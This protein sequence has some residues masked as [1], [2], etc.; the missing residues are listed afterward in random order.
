MEYIL[1]Q[2]INGVCQGAIYALMA[3]GYSVVVGVT[4]MVT[5]THGEVM[6]IGA[7]ASFYIFQY[8]GSHIVLGLLGAFAASWIL[9][10]LVY[11]ICYEHFFN[12]PRHISLICTVGFSMLVQNLAQICFGANKKP[13]LNIIENRVF[14][15]GP[16]RISMIQVAIV[17]I[18]LAL[19]VLLTVYF[20]RTRA[21]MALRAVSQDKSAAYLVGISVKK[22]AMIGNC[23]G[24]GIGGVAGMLMAIYYQ[25]CYAT[26]GST[27]SMKA[28]SSSVLGGMT[29]VRFSALGGLCIGVIEN[30]GIT[31]SSA[32]FRDAFAFCFLILVLIIRP[33]GF[34]VKKGAR[35]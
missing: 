31:F 5:F 35:P 7:F 16:V 9:G 32:S 30:L 3:I 1:N 12:A 17:V 4:G 34:S 23:I 6:M 13:V 11:K 28:F 20:N 10:M 15:I 8:A 21:G 19:A 27:M 26:M 22:T 14:K 24:C 25:T 18:V 2:L 33:H 29:D